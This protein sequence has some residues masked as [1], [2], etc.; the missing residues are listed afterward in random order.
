MNSYIK[1]PCGENFYT[2]LGPEF[3]PDEGNL[4]VI[5]LALYGLKS[6]GAP[7][8]NHLAGCMKHMGYKPCLSEPDLWMIP[9]TK[10]IDGLGYYE[11]VLIYVDEVISIGDDPEEVPKRVD[12]Y[13]GLK[14]GSL[15]VPNIY[16]GASVKL[17]ELPNGVMAWSLIQSKY[18]QEALKNVET[19]VKENLRERWK[20]PKTA[21]N[22]FPIG[23]KP[24][25]DVTPELDPE[26]S[27]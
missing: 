18:V 9:K 27:S 14:P 20:I 4:D 8:W 22:P 17:M 2:I 10:K 12:K 7:F 23:Y 3:G 15:A 21:V 6:D 16:L 5:V 19:Y 26:L 1:S 13:F 25:E 11:Y 24:T